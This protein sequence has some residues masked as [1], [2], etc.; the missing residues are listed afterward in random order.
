VN[1]FNYLEFY[2]DK[3]SKYKKNRLQELKN[4][5]SELI[6]NDLS[7]TLSHTNNSAV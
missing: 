5:G 3:H 1:D 6:G 7:V 4:K 2:V